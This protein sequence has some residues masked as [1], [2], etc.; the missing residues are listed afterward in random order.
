M[1]P[2]E[3]AQDGSPHARG[4]DGV[5]FFVA[6]VQTGF[7][8]FVA[9]YFVKIEW[10]AQAIDRALTIGTMSNLLSQLP[11]GAFINNISDK[12]QVVLV[13]IAGVGLAAILLD[14]KAAQ[15]KSFSPLALQGLASSLMGLIG[16]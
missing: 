12:R 2:E 10:A 1:P 3:L 8:L 15:P 4:R 11:A 14:A 7:G 13:G 6:A 5:N 16:Q 9:V